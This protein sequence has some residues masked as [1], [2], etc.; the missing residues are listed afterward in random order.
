MKAREERWSKWLVMSDD[1]V[2][3]EIKPDGS[4]V[5]LTV[6]M[7]MACTSGFKV[8]VALAAVSHTCAL[9][10]EQKIGIPCVILMEGS[11]EGHIYWCRQC[12][13]NHCKDDPGDARV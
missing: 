10:S 6:A 11:A 9:C 5:D 2:V 1:H 12:Y 13:S 4:T 7:A 8:E 3:I